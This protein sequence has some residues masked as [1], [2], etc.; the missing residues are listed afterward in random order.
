MQ[1]ATYLAYQLADQSLGHVH[2]LAD[3][4]IRVGG[5]LPIVL[6]LLLCGARTGVAPS[7]SRVVSSGILTGR[8]IIDSSSCSGRGAWARA[9]IIAAVGHRRVSILCSTCR[10]C[11][12]VP[13]AF[14]SSSRLLLALQASNEPNE[15]YQR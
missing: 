4:T 8:R 5:V 11:L 10:V 1:P 7:R 3:L 6:R 15:A 14:S 13:M 2:H 12:G 9:V